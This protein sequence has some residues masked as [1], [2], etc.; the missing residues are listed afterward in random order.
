MPRHFLDQRNREHGDA[1][2]GPLAL[3]NDELAVRKID[4]LHPKAQALHE[5]H[6]RAVQQLGHQGM[7]AFHPGEHRV[8][9]E[10]RQDDGEPARF[11]GARDALHP[12]KVHAKYLAVEE[13]QRSKRLVLGGG[14]DVAI[15][16]ERREERGHMLRTKLAR[17]AHPVEADVAAHPVLV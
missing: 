13:Q 7:R 4:I 14:R 11:L 12:R 3:A 5:P 2:L 15:D 9:L 17:V 10:P 1:V 16:G 6:A 8:R